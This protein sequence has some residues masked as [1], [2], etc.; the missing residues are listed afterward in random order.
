MMP[1]GWRGHSSTT[2]G[3]RPASVARIRD[4]VVS[5]TPF[6]LDPWLTNVSCM[7]LARRVRDAFGE[8][9]TTHTGFLLD[10]SIVNFHKPR[11][12]TTRSSS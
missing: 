6:S 4:A 2:V 8:W 5:A 12:W 11:V 7:S 3:R 9:S 1:S 10:S